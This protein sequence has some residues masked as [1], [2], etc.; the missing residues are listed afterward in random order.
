MTFKGKPSWGK[1]HQQLWC[2]TNSGVSFW[3]NGFLAEFVDSVAQA[4]CKILAR[5]GW[6]TLNSNCVVRSYMVNCEGICLTNELLIVFIIIIYHR[7]YCHLHLDFNHSSFVM[8]GSGGNFTPP[9]SIDIRTWCTTMWV[10]FPRFLREISHVEFQ[11]NPSCT[12][13][14]R[15]VTVRIFCCL[16]SHHPKPTSSQMASWGD[17]SHLARMISCKFVSLSSK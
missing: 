6:N 12:P 11:E 13:G 14:T 15:S 3:P 1:N 4:L 7:Y 10:G 2:T 17:H 16:V 9:N 5:V 8:Q